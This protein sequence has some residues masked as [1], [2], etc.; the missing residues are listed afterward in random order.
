MLAPFPNAAQEKDLE[1]E[2]AKKTR[3]KG[4]ARK[5]EPKAEEGEKKKKKPKADSDK[6]NGEKKKKVLALK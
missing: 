4:E 5:K 2:R 1:A 3:T 6:K